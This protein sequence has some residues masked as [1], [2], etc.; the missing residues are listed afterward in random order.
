[1]FYQAGIDLKIRR[2][3]FA[4]L[5]LT[6]KVSDALEVIKLEFL[7]FPFSLLGIGLTSSIIIFVCEL[8]HY[9]RM[10]MKTG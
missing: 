7:I 9:R 10:K 1:M 8:L 4:K 2:K 3:I 6:P 5:L